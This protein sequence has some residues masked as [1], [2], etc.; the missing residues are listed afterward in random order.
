[1]ST[2][3]TQLQRYIAIRREFGHD[4]S[5]TERALKRFAAFGDAQGALFVTTDLFLAWKK[6]FGAASDYTWT[7]RLGMVRGFAAWAHAI[8]P[9][10]EIPPAGLFPHP[11]PR[12]KPY[13][14]SVDEIARLVQ[15]AGR[16]PSDYGLRGHTYAALFGLIAATGLR[17]NEALGLDEDDVDLATGALHIR[18]GKNGKARSIPIGMSVATA[19][20]AY[21]L[22][23][24]RILAGPNTPFFLC[25]HS[26]RPTDCG[27]RYNFSVVCRQIGLRSAQRFKRH[28]RGPRIHDLRHTFAVRTIMDWYRQGLNADQQMF[29]LSAYLGHERP[30]FTY[31]YIEA[32]PELLRLA[33]DRAEQ[34]LT[35]AAP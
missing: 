3:S 15:A 16:L 27:A 20:D 31:W 17:I 22:E 10:H 24:R 18:R 8:D 1:M 21:R 26:R 23:R 4:L 12:P 19:L 35:G 29:K 33:S 13:I 7:A 6:Q 32:F 28:G 9:G 11:S 14:Y 5:T 25:E 30:E 2:L 34:A